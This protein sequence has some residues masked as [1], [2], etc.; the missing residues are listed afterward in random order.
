MPF[1]VERHLQPG[2]NNLVLLGHDDEGL[3][4]A[5]TVSVFLDVPETVAGDAAV[6]AEPA[7]P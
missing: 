1:T 6:P 3:T 2:F 5:H 7:R 4:V